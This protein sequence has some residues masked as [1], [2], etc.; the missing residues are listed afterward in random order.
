MKTI[1]RNLQKSASAVKVSSEKVK[2]FVTD[3]AINGYKNAT[4]F[5]KATLRKI[6]E[7][8][9]E[10]TTCENLLNPDVR[11]FAF[12]PISIQQF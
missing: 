3:A 1:C 10:I 7:Y 9:E 5:I 6:K 4:A 12:S 2:E 8:S 11:S